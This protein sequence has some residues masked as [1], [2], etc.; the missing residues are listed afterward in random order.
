MQK[1]DI[2]PWPYISDIEPEAKLSQ[3]IKQQISESENF[4]I[5]L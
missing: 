3:M 2:K 1:P 5:S 4:R